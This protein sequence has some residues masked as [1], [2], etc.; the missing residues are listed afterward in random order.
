METSP[1][2]GSD[3]FLEHKQMEPL[4]GSEKGRKVLSPREKSQDVVFKSSLFFTEGTLLFD[5]VG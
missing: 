5:M 1:L 2:S 4:R 3:V